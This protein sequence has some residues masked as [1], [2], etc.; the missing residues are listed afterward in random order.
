MNKKVTCKLVVNQKDTGEIDFEIKRRPLSPYDNRLTYGSPTQLKKDK[1]LV[2]TKKNFARLPSGYFHL[3]GDVVLYNIN[4]EGLE[5]K[6]V[7]DRI[8]LKLDDWRN[9]SY[10]RYDRNRQ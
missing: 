3:L 8:E 7:G 4:L 5:I 2:F 6:E 10:E 1:V 9:Y